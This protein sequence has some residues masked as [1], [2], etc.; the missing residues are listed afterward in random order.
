MFRGQ[1]KRIFGQEPEKPTFLVPGSHRVVSFPPRGYGLPYA[2]GA[3]L[4]AKAGITSS[5]NRRSERSACAWA[6]VPQAN[7]Q[8]T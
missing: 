6:K 8:I 5:A 4:P 1:C 2:T 3:A 7:A